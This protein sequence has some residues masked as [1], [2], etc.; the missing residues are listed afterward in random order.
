MGAKLGPRLGPLG[1]AKRYTLYFVNRPMLLHAE[2]AIA[3]R[4]PC[5]VVAK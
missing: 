3:Q 5:D 2:E 1:A 4:D